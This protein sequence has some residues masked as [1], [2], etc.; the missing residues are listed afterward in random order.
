MRCSRFIRLA[1]CKSI[2]CILSFEFLFVHYLREIRFNV[3][4]LDNCVTLFQAI[5]GNF[6]QPWMYLGKQRAHYK[7]ISDI[8][9]GVALD[10]DIP[11]LLSLGEDRL[12]V[13][14]VCLALPQRLGHHNS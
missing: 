12:M 10:S 8:A 7:R 13:R 5:P 2:S 14:C 6:K 4:D 11:R 1:Y 3:Q 9:F